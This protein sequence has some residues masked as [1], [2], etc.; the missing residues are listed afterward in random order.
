MGNG[1]I[2]VGKTPTR[3]TAQPSGGRWFGNNVLPA[4]PIA[5]RVTPRA[6]RL[7]GGGAM[8]EQ[9]GDI[10]RGDQSA[11]QKL[12]QLVGCREPEGSPN[13][14]TELVRPKRAREPKL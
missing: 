11:P 3:K 9:R 7:L 2:D 14:H 6:E 8:A 10:G 5:E 12:V 13:R 1:N 4:G